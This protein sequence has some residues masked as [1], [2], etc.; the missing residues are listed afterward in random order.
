MDDVLDDDY[1]F[2]AMA[3]TQICDSFILFEWHLISSTHYVTINFLR[4]QFSSI[5]ILAQ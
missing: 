4:Q 5:R 3:Y 1:T 2:M